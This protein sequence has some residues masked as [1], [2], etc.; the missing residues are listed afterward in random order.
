MSDAVARYAQALKERENQGRANLYA[1]DSNP[2]QAAK[3][4]SLARET[5]LPAGTIER[6]LGEVERR[7]QYRRAATLSERYPAIGKW[8]SDPSNAAIGRDDVDNLGRVAKV[9]E[10]SLSPRPKA[11]PRRTI[12]QSIRTGAANVGGALLAGVGE[13]GRGAYGLGQNYLDL[14]EEFDPT[15]GLQR[16]L[17]GGTIYDP[18]QKA[19]AALAESARV[20]AEARR[21]KVE[22]YYARSALQGVES[23][24][25][26]VTALIATLAGRPDA[27]L[28]LLGGVTA[29]G[30][31]LEGRKEGLSTTQATGYGLTQG[32][33]EIL[34][35][36]IPIGKYFADVQAG[37]PFFKRLMNNLLTENIG[38]QAATVL[39]DL[40]RW[41]AVDAN[42]GKTFGDYLAERP[43]AALTTLI[44]TSTG[45]V[46][47]NAATGAVDQAG[48]KIVGILEAR[49]KA[50][51]AQT[52]AEFLTK[53]SEGAVESKVRQRD[54]S[55]FARFIEIQAEGSPVENLYIPGEAIRELYQSNDIDWH[56]SED[57]YFGFDPSISE[58]IDQAIA[59]GGDVVV[60]TSDFA[61][62][63]AGT[64]AWDALKD[65]VRTS[66]DGM[67]LTEAK[68]WETAFTDATNKT[69]EE[70][71]ALLEQDRAEQEP[72]QKIAEAMRDKL[73]LA[74]F[75]PD[76]AMQYA[77]LTAARAA[78]RAA[79][80]GQELTGTEADALEIQQ[81]TEGVPGD[82]RV[83]DQSLL[84]RALV[85]SSLATTTPAQAPTVTVQGAPVG[86]IVA[87]NIDLHARPVVRNDDG[88]IS[89]VRSMSIGTDQGEVLIPTVS[90]DGRILGDQEAVQLYEQTGKHL[91]IFKNPEAA[92][93]Y[94]EDLHKAQEAEYRS[95]EQ[96]D[97]GGPR[98][99]IIFKT[100]GKSVIELF[101]SRNLSSFIHESGHLYLEELKAD[102]ESMVSPE[103]FAD[104]E[105]VKA[106]FKRE[107]IKM[108]KDGSI[109]VEAHELWAR[110]F[111][112]F[113]MEGKAPS[114]ALRKA[115]DAFRS[116]LLN[117]YKVVDNLRSPI[118]PEIRG[119]M[120]RLIATDEEIKAAREEQNIKALFSTAAEAGMTDA[121]FGAYQ[122]ATV[123][124]RDEA[125]DALLYRT[126]AAIRRQKTLAWKDEEAG[127]RAEVSER[128]DREPVF[129]AIRLLQTGK[130]GDGEA[131]RV[132]LSRQWLLETYGADALS[133]LPKRVP[134]IYAD[135]KTIDADTIAEMTG[136]AT[137]DELV[138]MLMGLETRQR[139]LREGGDKRSVRQAQIDEET[140]LIMLDR[141]GDIL[142]DGSIEDE[143]RALVHN[144]KTGEVIASEIRALAR[145][146]NKRPTPYAIARQW[147]AEKIASSKVVHATSGSALASYERAARRASKAAEAAMLAQDIDKTY[148]QKQ[149]QML[150]NALIAEGKKA[151]DAVDLAVRRLGKL[152]KR[153]TI[154][155]IDQGH[156]DQ[157]HGL[158]EQVE[159]KARSQAS[160]DRQESFEEWAAAQQA[161]GFDIVVPGSF[162]ASL[163]TTNWSRLSVEQL[164]GLDETVKQIVHLGRLKQ[165]LLDGKEQREF[166]D[167]VGE[168][169]LAAGNL[170]PSP[171][172]DLME[173]SRW[174]SIKS[175][176]ASIDAALLKMETVFDWLDGGNPNGVFNR[177]VFRRIAD[178]QDREKTMMSDYVGRLTDHLKAIPKEQIKRWTEKVVAPE[179]INRETGNPYQ[180]T[181]DQLVSMALNM[182]NEGNATKLAGG[183]GWS[184]DAIMRVLN[185]ELSAA[186][187]AYVQ[188]VW[189]TIDTLWPEIAALEKRLNGVEP[190]KVVAR[191]ISTPAGELKGGY[192]PVVYD[193]RKSVEADMMGQYSRDSLFENIYTRATTPKGFTKQR[194]TVERPIHLSLG[195]INR[196]V[197]EVIHD[198]TH[199]EAIIDADRFLS[200]KRV[201]KAVDDTL[202]PAIRKQF[203][204]WLQHIANEWAMDRTGN[205]GFEK[206]LKKLRTNVT[207]VGM[208][209][210]VST[211]QMQIAGLSNSAEVVGEKHILDGVAAFVKN[212]IQSWEFVSSR[213]GEVRNRM[214][215]L[216]RDIRDT[217]RR[218]AGTS[219]PITE[220]QRF[221]FYGIAMADRAVVIPTWLGAYNKALEAGETE[222]DAIYAADK[223]VRQSQS[224]GS[225]KDLAA[226][227]RGSGKAGE[228]MKYLTFFY[229]YMS[230]FYQRERTLGRDIMGLDERRPRNMPRLIARAWWLMAV[231][232]VLSELLA[233]REPEE[234]EDWGMWALQRILI[235][236]VGPIPIVRD[237][238][239]PL[240]KTLTEQRSFG[241]KFTPASRAIETLI[242]S[243]KDV[244]RIAKGEE[245]KRATRDALETAGYFTGLVPGQIATAAQFMVDVGYGDQEPESV[246]DW[247]EGLTEGK[248]EVD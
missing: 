164:L 121:E 6:N 176:V 221:Y 83:L 26:T 82:G 165:K 66:A 54:P 144:E 137:G 167:L 16:R 80:M 162:A 59:T 129:R 226:V 208:G 145:R 77:E 108:P 38:E 9:L 151:K 36:K 238:A 155:S 236:A 7:V 10:A 3:A 143:A 98:A 153:R 24:P 91:G 200:D 73:M 56:D 166:D 179:L 72:R 21:P 115:F 194:T 177:V 50:R 20:Y 39:Q 230:G 147:A 96:S 31:Y 225:A 84:L 1:I 169:Q 205:A 109:P 213:S 222:S 65:H 49:D 195:V 100:G 17:F 68:E 32:A 138:R 74:G 211:M 14:Q 199:R 247:W 188:Q 134:P 99:R 89:T 186:D 170:T 246:G 93:A 220:A 44:A 156:L 140:A 58:Q 135:Q 168:A 126:M 150:N 201:M 181:R 204:P 244:S 224:S 149:A 61:A 136:F 120:E 190:E 78:T 104:F 45:V 241:Y 219:N 161:A 243:V 207:V 229:S 85:A 159:F 228:L 90:D 76:V 171:P 240:V 217:V 75:R 173:P 35:E 5:G 42:K 53:L 71:A 146:A 212:P 111:E 52:D 133:L 103:V 232:A 235:S 114:S 106:W 157:V 209:L 158:L 94:A 203:R 132:K 184:E 48:K 4:Q 62:H 245:T 47:S 154:K 180:F 34:T 214:D 57:P 18:F 63:L 231:P 182:G 119:V 175:G 233:G 116:W 174:D 67:S 227:Q 193:P 206:F 163:G 142:N 128:V 13:A 185:R 160:L 30:S 86:Q 124:A 11:Q 69:G 51:Q 25:T 197:S 2:E 28:A 102:A 239:D 242:N 29:G 107:G 19:T 27:G 141:H 216:D 192:F 110:G 113:A 117:I 127:V 37:T 202:G 183:Y 15:V 196:H 8:S 55:A 95:F 118:S 218:Q 237:V 12:L 88:S 40:N 101:E 139:E 60:K 122:S 87:G 64:P 234:D 123:E 198:I 92:T 189:D 81:G 172:S 210:R 112:R 79:R 46:G 41:A 22:N 178:A 125:Y 130:L 187:W 131:Q 33:V 43:E 148:R 105:M 191:P 23:M 70:F 223:A 248:V 215:T 152:A 97:M